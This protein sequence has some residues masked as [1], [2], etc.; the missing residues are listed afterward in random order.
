MWRDGHFENDGK[1]GS[2]PPAQPRNPLIQKNAVFT[3]LV[4]DNAANYNGHLEDFLKAEGH[5][6]IRAETAQEAL[7]MTRQ[8]WPDLILL[9]KEMDGTNGL[10]FFPE[11]LAEHPSAAVIIMANLPGVSTVVDAMLLGAIDYLAR[12]LD[13]HRLKTSMDGQ[14]KL[15]DEL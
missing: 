6:V 9:N 2:I 3:T 4:V 5:Y 11:L 8:H 10:K 12:P 7:A 15:Y 14:R 1:A 13:T